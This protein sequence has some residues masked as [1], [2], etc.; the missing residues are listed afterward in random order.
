MSWSISL[1]FA[2]LIFMTFS[3]FPLNSSSNWL[4]KLFGLSSHIH[5]PNHSVV[6]RVFIIRQFFDIPKQRT[7]LCVEI[8]RWYVKTLGFNFKEFTFLCSRPL[9]TFLKYRRSYTAFTM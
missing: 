5:P 3:H 1:T 9:D 2:I 4:F 8:A 7:L 6:I